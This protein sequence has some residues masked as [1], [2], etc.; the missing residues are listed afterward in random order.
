MSDRLNALSNTIRNTT[1]NPNPLVNE[2]SAVENLLT[3]QPT[4]DQ[5]SGLQDPSG[6]QGPGSDTPPGSQPPATQQGG[7]GQNGK[8]VTR[9]TRSATKIV[10]AGAGEGTSSSPNPEPKGKEPSSNDPKQTDITLLLGDENEA[11]EPGSTASTKKCNDDQSPGSVRS[12]I[13]EEA[14]AATKAGENDKAAM[15][16]NVDVSMAPATETSAPPARKREREASI[17]ILGQSSDVQ[18]TRRE[19]GTIP[20]LS[21]NQIEF[22][23]EEVNTHKDVGFTP[24]FDKNLC[25]LRGPIPL[26]I[27]NK[28][29]QDRA[30]VYHAEKR[31]KSDNGS[32]EGR[33]RYTGYPYPSEWT[34]TFGEWTANHQGFYKTLRDVYLF[35]TFAKWVSTHKEHCDRIVAKNGFMA[36]LRYD[37]N[38]RTNVFAYRVMV[39]GKAAVADISIFRRDI[40]EDVYLDARHFS[41]LGLADN[42]YASNGAR[43]DWDP[44]TGAPKN[45]PRFPNQKNN[46]SR[47]SDDSNQPGQNG[48]RQ[49]KGGYQGKNFNPDFAKQKSQGGGS[50]SSK[51]PEN[52]S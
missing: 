13:M 45:A 17:E 37:V 7:K 25:E 52:T 14:I 10:V 21:E 24:Y 6:A 49:K 42:P 35:T 12:M 22:A 28:K 20:L 15:L 48:Q 16:W 19:R 38:V 1:P 34:Q 47:P 2:D 51:A 46:S 33:L 9:Y 3:N 8:K 23:S 18:E 40:F 26:T 27:F 41:E 5:P 32:L 44:L 31:T 50:N 30:I 43:A 4:G 29:W 11:T 39:N 36:G